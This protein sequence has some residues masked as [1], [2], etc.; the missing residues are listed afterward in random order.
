MRTFGP[1]VYR[2]KGLQSRMN[3]D[4]PTADADIRS[5]EFLDCTIHVLTAS[6]LTDLV[7]VAVRSHESCIIA[8]HNLH[9]LYLYQHDTK[10]RKLFSQAKWIHADGMGI[11]LLGKAFGVHLPRSARIT[12]VDWLPL[13]LDRAAARDWRLFYLGSKPGIADK[14]ADLLREKFPRLRL[15]TAHGYFDPMGEENDR[16]LDEIRVFAPD[17]LLV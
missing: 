15:K 13:L 11:V 10:L 2:K 9:S 14:G 6:D 12:Y 7:E 1:A 8:N 4:L 5:H 16:I 17:V 3:T